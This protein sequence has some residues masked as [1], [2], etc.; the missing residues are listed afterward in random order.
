MSLLARLDPGDSVTGLLLIVVLQTSVVT[1]LAALLGRAVFRR[2]A[3]ARHV[4][5][6]GVMILIL[7]SP[8]VAVVACR[9][10]VGLW[11][12]TLPTTGYGATPAAGDR[13][14]RPMR[15]RSDAKILTAELPVKSGGA[16][17]EPPDEAI[18]VMPYE[19]ASIEDSRAV[20]PELDR[21]G[22][23]FTGGLALLWAVVALASLGR[24]AMGWRQLAVLARSARTLD[25]MR[26]GATL[27]RVRNV[28]GIASL[29]SVVTS[30][31]VCG[32]VAV[33]VWRP[34]IVLPEGLAESIARSRM[35]KDAFGCCG[36]PVSSHFTA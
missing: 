11:V 21:G 5:W 30:T 7:I 29:P 31:R 20:R 36:Y 35:T 10:G 1:L 3:D 27:D 4:I 26:H 17:A 33:G 6:L 16:E 13:G 2:R 15:P 23:P 34:C 8:A 14:P 19:Q 12:V 25:P 24:T 32:P 18:G 28:F 22:S 9:L